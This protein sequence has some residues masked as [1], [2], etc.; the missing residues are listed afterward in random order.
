MRI[1][2]VRVH[3]Y[4]PLSDITLTDIGNFTLVFGENESGKTLLIDAILRFLLSGKRDRELFSRLDRVER[5]PDGFIEISRQDQIFRFPDDGSL[6]DL[7]DIHAKDLRNVLVVRASDLQVHEG[8]EKTYY[9]EIT[10][11]LTGIHREPIKKIRDKLHVIG[12][13]TSTGKLSDSQDYGKVASRIGDTK[14]LLLEI[15]ELNERPSETDMVALEAELLDAMERRVEATE[16]LERLQKA[17]KRER[18]E[19]GKKLLGGLEQCIKNIENLPAVEQ[20]HYDDW[21]DAEN[22]IQGTSK[23]LQEGEE[24]FGEREEE[25]EATQTEL[26]SARAHLQELQS[27]KPAVDDLERQAQKYRERVEAAASRSPVIGLLPRI[28]GALVL[29]LG[30]AFIAILVGVQPA[31]FT[32]AALILGGLLIIAGGAWLV[33][34]LS[35]GKSRK[36]WESLRLDA[37]RAGMKVEEFEDL[38]ESILGFIGEIEQAQERIT[39]AETQK[40]IV[41]S[42]VGIQEDQ[43]KKYRGEIA[44]AEETLRNL[45]EDTGLA[46]FEALEA[47]RAE[48]QGLEDLQT[49]LLAKLGAQFGEAGE[50]VEETLAVWRAR[51]Q[52]LAEYEEAAP[53]MDYDKA[54]EAEIEEQLEALDIRIA[55]LEEQLDG[56]RTEIAKI[57]SQANRLLAPDEQLPGDTFEDLTMIVKELRDF[58]KGVDERARLAWAAIELLNEIQGEEEQKVKGLFG[59]DD[60]ASQHFRAITG[61][62]YER[63]EYDP[64]DGELKVIRGNG[65]ALRAYSLSSGA[66]D[67]L[68]LATRLSLASQILGGEPGFLLLDDPFLTS[69]SKRLARQLEILK[70]LAGEGWQIVYFSVKEEVRDQLEDAKDRVIIRTM[71]SLVDTN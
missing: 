42:S 48:L 70:Q 46:S 14:E 41:S 24:E 29:L 35:E 55:E 56:I 57:S 66:Y 15:N 20:E 40:G 22:T 67:Q 38:L 64:D 8:E 47:T 63:V 71:E 60:V 5:N 44:E 69:D 11:R 32:V 10:D 31:F 62:A 33:D 6:P 59:E 16:E 9:A 53:G 43:I 27:R 30:L 1:R 61:G 68:Y 58:V 28:G 34:R 7:L 39:R 45:K 3:R 25:L 13:L 49:A 17:K 21:R 18:Y 23:A 19:S 65:E 51:I 54:R 26:Q 50:H 12:M 37:A 2:E 52:E 36:A 4:G